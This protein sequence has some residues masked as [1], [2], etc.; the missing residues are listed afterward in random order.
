MSHVGLNATA[1]L[2]EHL[3]RFPDAIEKVGRDDPWLLLA[4]IRARSL[5]LLIVHDVL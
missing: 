5:R 2:I 3:A 4:E 1:A